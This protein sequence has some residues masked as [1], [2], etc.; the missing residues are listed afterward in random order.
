MARHKTNKHKTT[1]IQI[2]EKT[3]NNRRTNDKNNNTKS[4]KKC[5]NEQNERRQLKLV[6]K[7]ELGNESK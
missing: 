2:Y 7:I 5:R 3:N 6:F 1:K 4:K